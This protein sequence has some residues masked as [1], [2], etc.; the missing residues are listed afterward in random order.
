MN[1]LDKV[2]AK[3][4]QKIF[5]VSRFFIGLLFFSHGAQKLFGMFGGHSTG[6]SKE[7]L[8]AGII[9]FFGG[10]LFALGLET[11]YIAIITACEM[12]FA[13][14]TVH[15]H[16]G[17]FPIQNGGELALLYFFFF[18]FTIVNGGGAW[19]VDS[20]ILKKK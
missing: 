18:L 6:G 8:I 17:R 16:M 4:S 11:R 19:S 7:M 10:L 15:S 3:L 13:Y 14:I 1:V 20:L 12:A 9:E 2:S 5:S